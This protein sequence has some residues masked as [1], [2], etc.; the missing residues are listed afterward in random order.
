MDEIASSRIAPRCY[1][2]SPFGATNLRVQRRP[3][4]FPN[5]KLA[6]RPNSRWTSDRIRRQLR[7]PLYRRAPNASFDF[8]KE[9]P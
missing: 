4:P 7:T 2:H 9:P 5:H 6:A 3:S 1:S 8:G